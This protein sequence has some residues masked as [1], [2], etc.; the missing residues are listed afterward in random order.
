MGTRRGDLGVLVF[1]FPLFLTCRFP[2]CCNSFRLTFLLFVKCVGRRNAHQCPYFIFYH[3][4]S[5]IVYGSHLVRAVS[6]VFFRVRK[7]RIATWFRQMF[8]PIVTW[9]SRIL[10]KSFLKCL[11]LGRSYCQIDTQP[12][13]MHR[14]VTRV[15]PVL[16]SS[17]FCLASVTIS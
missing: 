14:L 10:L 7:N 4:P 12:K 13:D 17:W 8:T 15:K 2:L 5:S 16:S 9:S 3:T 1:S 11:G 6:V